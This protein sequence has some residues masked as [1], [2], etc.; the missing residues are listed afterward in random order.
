[1]KTAEDVRSKAQPARRRPVGPSPTPLIL[2]STEASLREWAPFDNSSMVQYRTLWTDPR[3]GSYAGLLRL[4]AG[5]NISEHTHGHAVHHIWVAAGCCTVAG[6]HMEKGSYMH[7]PAT[8]KHGIDWAGPA[9]C[10]L[11]YLYLRP[12]SA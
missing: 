6:R 11:F 12:E 4:E 8:A 1:M 5:A 2:D 9:G 7:V 10:T 3:S